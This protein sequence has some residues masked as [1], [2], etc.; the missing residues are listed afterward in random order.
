MLAQPVCISITGHH[1]LITEGEKNEVVTLGMVPYCH[2]CSEA[3]GDYVWP[4]VRFDIEGLKDIMAYIES[5]IV[6]L[7]AEAIT[8]GEL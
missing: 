8:D 3:A 4:C 7:E 5:K 2:E 1:V 6:V